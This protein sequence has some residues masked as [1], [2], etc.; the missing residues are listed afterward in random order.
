[1]GAYSPAPVVTPRVHARIVREIITPAMR[2]MK[3]DGIPYSGFLYAGLMIDRAGDPKV[4]EFNCRLGD[5]ETQ[6]ILMRLKSDLFELLDHAVEGKLDR[7]EAN[8][9]RRTA[10]GVVL[11]A[12]NYP[13]T[14]RKGD[15]ITGFPAD[16]ED[17]HV[18]HA[19][20]DLLDGTVV[21]N[22]G[23][24]LCVTALGDSVRT[25]QKRAYDAIA[26]TRFDGM[27]YRRDIGHH[28]LK[29]RP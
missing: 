12:Q 16:D 14:P 21:T 17:C 8:W 13:D 29:S 18:F 9:D 26:Q 6:P 19:G 11:A 27:Q 22:G 2:G 1:M 28:A 3:D 7:F 25:A 24:V 4:L 5:P 15:V 10:L 23:R 20:T